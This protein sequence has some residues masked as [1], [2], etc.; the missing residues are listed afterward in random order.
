V[1]VRYWPL[2]RSLQFSPNLHQLGLLVGLASLSAFF[3]GLIVAYSFRIEA[4]TSWQRFTVPKLL[5]L[6]LVLLGLSSWLVEASRF[7]LRR[8]MVF[9]YRMRL[10]TAILF[11]LMFVAVQVMAGANLV[12][13]GVVAKA[14]PHGSAFYLFIGIHGV[15]LTAGLVWLTYL[16]RRSR[17]LFKASENDLRRHR[18][19]AAV[20]AGYW[21]F[22]GVVWAVLFFFLLLWTRG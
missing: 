4:D 10:L 17:K 14:N 8:A 11:G 16:Y 18:V 21:H 1:T 5:W 12:A 15:H 22:M 13:Q 3:I 6:S 20:A 7:A 2:R 9:R 19:V